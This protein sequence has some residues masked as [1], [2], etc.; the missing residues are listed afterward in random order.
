MHTLLL[1]CSADG[2]KGC[3]EEGGGH[4]NEACAAHSRQLKGLLKPLKV[5]SASCRSRRCSNYGDQEG[6][7]GSFGAKARS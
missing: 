4:E 1:S 7:G 3:R 5:N 6:A 2:K